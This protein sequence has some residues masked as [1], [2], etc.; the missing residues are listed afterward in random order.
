MKLAIEVTPEQQ[1]RLKA[2]ADRLNIPVESLAAAA[3]R[4]LVALPSA[5]FEAAADE[6]LNK[7]QE[8][9]ERLA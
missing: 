7:N 6:L 5:E 4:E 2:T 8:L 1:K 3:V 9:Y